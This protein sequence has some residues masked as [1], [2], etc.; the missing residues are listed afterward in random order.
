M[1]HSLRASALAD[2][3]EDFVKKGQSRSGE[4]GLSSMLASEFPGTN[5]HDPFY[6][7]CKRS[8]WREAV[9]NHTPEGWQD[10]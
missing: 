10:K 8:V 6:L 9:L 5:I 1:Q 7:I 2:K 3:P 4:Q